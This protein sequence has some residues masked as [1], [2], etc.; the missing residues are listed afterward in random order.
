MDCSILK[1]FRPLHCQENP[2]SAIANASINMSPLIKFL[3]CVSV[4]DKLHLDKSGTGDIQ[5]SIHSESTMAASSAF[6]MKGGH[7][8]KE[9]GGFHI[10]LRLTAELSRSCASRFLQIEDS[11]L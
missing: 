2:G 8:N 4:S 3:P 9:T 10:I 1:Y 5:M 7:S 6:L 11:L